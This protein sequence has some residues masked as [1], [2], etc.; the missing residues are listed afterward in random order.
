MNDK[1]G[2]GSIGLRGVVRQLS[3]RRGRN[4]SQDAPSPKQAPRIVSRDKSTTTTTGNS[5]G[6][7]RS[8]SASS[9]TTSIERSVPDDDRIADALAFQPKLRAQPRRGSRSRRVESV[10]GPPPA[11]QESGAMNMFGVDLEP[12]ASRKG[13]STL[14]QPIARTKNPFAEVFDPLPPSAA[15]LGLHGR[16][17]LN[18]R[19][20]SSSG[21][22]GRPSSRERI[23]GGLFGSVSTASKKKPSIYGEPAR[24]SFDSICTSTAESLDEPIMPKGSVN[25]RRSSTLRTDRDMG[26]FKSR[27]EQRAVSSTTRAKPSLD[28]TRSPPLPSSPFNG[29]W[30]PPKL[31]DDV[32]ELSSMTLSSPIL[33][34]NDDLELAGEAKGDGEG[35]WALMQ[36]VKDHMRAKR[37][38]M[39][40]GPFWAVQRGWK[41]GVF[42][43]Q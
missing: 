27:S 5:G 24:R 17:K 4:A 7:A 8:F 29:Y 6:L 13:S 9:S 32:E 35:E 25:V 39:G 23:F 10:W 26:H 15:P 21:F 20:S 42:S 34:S 16:P 19:Y 38:L 2:N 3:L 28:L 36:N 40:H 18:A 30:A 37:E 22:P 12:Q 14:E 41:K 31:D 1:P 43:S 33:A 11:S